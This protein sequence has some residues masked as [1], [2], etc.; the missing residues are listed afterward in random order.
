LK[1]SNQRIIPLAGQL[2]FGKQ[3]EGVVQMSGRPATKR[4][5]FLLNINFALQSS[6]LN[7]MQG[8]VN[9]SAGNADEYMP[10]KRALQR[11]KKAHKK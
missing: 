4:G 5:G 8:E 3:I 2:L 9:R 6:L 1:K 10:A 7:G 11:K